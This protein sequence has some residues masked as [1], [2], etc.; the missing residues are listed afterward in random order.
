MWC[1]GVHARESDR[2]VIGGRT[3]IACD[4]QRAESVVRTEHS[5]HHSVLVPV[6]GKSPMGA[7]PEGDA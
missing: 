3:S 4:R 6:G 2:T 5:R 7:C 1:T